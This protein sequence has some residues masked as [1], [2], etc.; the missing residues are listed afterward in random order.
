MLFVCKLGLVFVEANMHRASNIHTNDKCLAYSWNAFNRAYSELF[1]LLSALR[2]L[3]ARLQTVQNKHL[4][5]HSE[6]CLLFPA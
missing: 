5:V 2:R 4:K 1:V 3:N 6:A